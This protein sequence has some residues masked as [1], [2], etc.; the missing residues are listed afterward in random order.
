[1]HYLFQHT[2][3]ALPGMN[4]DAVE[5]A[6]LIEDLNVEERDEDEGICDISEEHTIADP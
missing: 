4:P 6:E 3:Q 5:T 2:G 1:M